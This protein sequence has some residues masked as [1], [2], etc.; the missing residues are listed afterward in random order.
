MRWRVM[1]LGREPDKA[2]DLLLH[3]S[4]KSILCGCPTP[5]GASSDHVVKAAP[6][7]SLCCIISHDQVI[8][9][10]CGMIDAMVPCKYFIY[11]DS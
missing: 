3:H 9:N 7:G 10:I 8:P 1:I 11:C 5:R 6:A 2:V 4:G